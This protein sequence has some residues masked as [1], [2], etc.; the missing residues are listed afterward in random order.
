MMGKRDDI[1]MISVDTQDIPI[2]VDWKN[3]CKKIN[4][5]GGIKDRLMNLIKEDLKKLKGEKK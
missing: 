1:L 3:Q 4:F 5:N 2:L